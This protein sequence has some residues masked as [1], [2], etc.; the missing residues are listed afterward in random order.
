MIETK[1]EKSGDVAVVTMANPPA[2]TFTMELGAGLEGAVHRAASEGARA[3]VLQAD[4]PLFCG[5][6]DVH[7]FAGSTAGQAREMFANG[8]RL[9]NAGGGAVPGYRRG[10]R[11]VFRGGPGAG[12]GL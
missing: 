5:G 8:F 2:N 7:L 10:P 9:I 6:A 3:L 4:G 1:Y 12:P 11:D